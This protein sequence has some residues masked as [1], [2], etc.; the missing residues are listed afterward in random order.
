MS[1]Y[2]HLW[3]IINNRQIRRLIIITVREIV[4][5]NQHLE[6]S[7]HLSK[8]MHKI[9]PHR[10]NHL[11][12]KGPLCQDMVVTIRWSRLITL[13][14]VGLHK[15][16][17]QL[18]IVRHK[19]HSWVKKTLIELAQ[20]SNLNASYL[21]KL[22]INKKTIRRTKNN[23]SNKCLK[24]LAILQL[25]NSSLQQIVPLLWPTP[26]ILAALLVPKATWVAAPSPHSTDVNPQ[27]PMTQR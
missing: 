19:H 15:N 11:G 23:Q 24:M 7:K 18:G 6:L 25:P 14:L 16:L 9:N 27:S 26:A 8:S 22:Q 12:W 20:I 21:T 3:R 10:G 5:R 2:H 4:L 1:N 13:H 17:R